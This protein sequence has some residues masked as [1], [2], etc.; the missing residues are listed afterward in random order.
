MAKL[1]NVLSCALVIIVSFIVGYYIG[2]S[3]GFDMGY[4]M[5]QLPSLLE[6]LEPKQLSEIVR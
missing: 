3:I 2:R 5:A 6:G 1:E 4:A